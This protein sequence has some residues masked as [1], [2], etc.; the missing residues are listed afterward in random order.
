MQIRI[1]RGSV[2]PRC[3]LLMSTAAAATVGKVVASALTY[4]IENFRLIHVM[5]EKDKVRPTLRNL[6]R[7]YAGFVPYSLFNSL[8]TFNLMFGLQE[9]F[10]YLAPEAALLA[11]V[12]ITVAVTSLYKVP[13][14]YHIKNRAV[15]RDVEGR[16]ASG[17]FGRAYSVLILEDVPEQFIKFH[18]NGV[19]AAMPEVSSVASAILVAVLTTLTTSPTDILKQRVFCDLRVPLSSFGVFLRALASTVNTVVFMLVFNTMAA[20]A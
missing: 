13:C 9:Y 20:A 16:M 5:P 2:Q 19:L 3:G 11:S 18:L 12:A 14:M 4:P 17:V 7:G 8:T 15:H 10:R 6:Y 1:G